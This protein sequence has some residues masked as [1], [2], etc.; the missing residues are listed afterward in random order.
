MALLARLQTD[1]SLARYAGWF[2][3]LKIETNG[4][5]W[6]KW[7]SQYQHEGNAIPIVFV[8][9]ADGQ[10]LF[11]K[12]GSMP[13][14][15]LP[16]M[17]EQVLGQ[18]GTIYSDAQ[19][20][21][22]NSSL[23]KAKE[24][25]AA[26]DTAGTVREL[27]KV[28]KLGALGGLGSYAQA[29]IEADDLAKKLVE[30]GGAALKA[31]NDQLAQETTRLE[32]ALALSE[33]KRIYGALPPLRNDFAAAASAARKDPHIRE[34]LRLAEQLDEAREQLKKPAGQRR[35]LTVLNRLISEH[36]GTPAAKLAADWLR[37]QNLTAPTVEPAKTLHVWTSDQGTTLEAALV[38]F[39][40]GQPETKKEPYV[41]L[42]KRDGQR[43]QVPLDRLAAKSQEE[44]IENVR[45]L[46][47]AGGPK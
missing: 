22:L 16:L 5:E 21:I 19:L 29:A 8:V 11:G 15:E 37:A 32:G 41:I 4:P 6:G 1:Q 35:A 14:P 9:R 3:P 10:Q 20:Q 25:F 18:A 27:S 47:A 36:P 34:L 38:D 33:A 39:G 40:Y 30:Q 7:A 44:A 45:R 23:G 17:I 12:S 42:E 28:G 26:G 46:R 13:G 43:V 2:I 24:L 31:A